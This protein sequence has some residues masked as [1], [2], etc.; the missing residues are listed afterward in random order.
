[1]R[2]LVTNRTV[3]ERKLNSFGRLNELQN[4]TKLLV[5]DQME[6]LRIWMY[7]ELGNTHDELPVCAKFTGC[8]SN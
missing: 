1:M 4:S 5:I 2:N 3:V 6:M 8:G 7:S